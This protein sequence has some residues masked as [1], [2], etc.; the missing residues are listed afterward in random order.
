[1]IAPLFSKDL[2]MDYVGIDHV[3]L[4]VKSIEASL[5]FYCAILGMQ[6]VTFG[7]N[8]KAILCGAQKFNLHEMGKEFEPKAAHPI[9]GSLDICLIVKTP[10]VDIIE[11]L[12]KHH[13]KII[14]GPVERTGARGKI[15]SVYI[16]DPDLNLVEMSNYLN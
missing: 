15:L 12:Q 6:E 3:V 5:H 7:N 13:I 16:R 14:E 11:H 4:T 1:M 10:L 9:P 2:I 8:R